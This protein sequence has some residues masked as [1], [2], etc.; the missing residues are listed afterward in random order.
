MKILL[1]PAFLLCAALFVAHQF[2]Q[3]V[4]GL[5]L[6]VLDSYLDP[7]LCMPIL[8]SLFLAERRWLFRKSNAYVLPKGEVLG[9]VLILTVLFEVGFPAFSTQFT[10]DVWDAVAYVIG[11]L[12]FYKVLNRNKIDKKTSEIVKISEV[13]ETVAAN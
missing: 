9:L 13:E 5:A 12:F 7:L 2:S 11:G 8:L 1:H 4:F 3:K 6:P 10:G